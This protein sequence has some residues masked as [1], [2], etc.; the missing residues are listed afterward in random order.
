MSIDTTQRITQPSRK[1]NCKNYVEFLDINPTFLLQT[2]LDYFTL[3]TREFELKFSGQR[4]IETN[5]ENIILKW[6]A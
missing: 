2:L 1:G 5:K 6:Y 3:M 4:V